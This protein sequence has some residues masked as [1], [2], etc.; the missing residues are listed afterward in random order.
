M[1]GTQDPLGADGMQFCIGC[2]DQPWRTFWQSAVII[3]EDDNQMIFAAN[4]IAQ[5]MMVKSADMLRDLMQTAHGSTPNRYR[6]KIRTVN[7]DVICI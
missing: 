1:T 7:G 3:I 6:L 2:L 4:P 5:E